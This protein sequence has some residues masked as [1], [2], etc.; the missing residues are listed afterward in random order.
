M[1][2]TYVVFSSNKNVIFKE[3]KKRIL[4]KS[5][6]LSINDY[7]IST[8]KYTTYSKNYV[9]LTVEIDEADKFFRGFIIKSGDEVILEVKRGETIKF[10]MF[11]KMSII[12]F[13]DD[14]EK[15]IELKRY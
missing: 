2:G 5:L 3:L 11:G 4:Y 9:D 13:D 1:I 6:I 7:T 10:H 12:R 15:L 8:N 14:N